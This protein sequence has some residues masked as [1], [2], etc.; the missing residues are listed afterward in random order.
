[1]PKRK[2]TD[3]KGEAIVPSMKPIGGPTGKGKKN[4]PVVPPAATVNAGL[5]QEI[6]LPCTDV[7]L[8]GRARDANAYSSNDAPMSCVWSRTSGPAS[9]TFS[10]PWAEANT[11]TF[12]QAG[13]YV[14]RLTRTDSGA[15]DELTV[16]VKSADSQTAFYVDP[17]YSGGANDGSAAHPW[18]NFSVTAGNAIWTA[19]NAALASNH[20]IVYFSARQAGSDTAETH[21]TEINLWRTDT[22]SHRLTLDGMSKYNAND[23]TPSWQDY[24]GSSRF[25]LDISSGSISIGIQDQ[26]S[27]PMNYTTIRGLEITG[28]NGRATVGGN[29]LVFERNNVHDTTGIGPTVMFHAAV[30]PFTCTQFLGNLERITFRNNTIARGVGEALYIAGTYILESDGGCPSWGNTHSDVLIESN[31]ITDPGYNS[32]GD[33]QGDG[34]DVKA[35]IRNVT[36][37]YNTIANT[38]EGA[39]MITQGA[40]GIVCSGVFTPSVT[41]TNYLIECNRLD[42]CRESITATNQNGLKIRNNILWSNPSVVIGNINVLQKDFSSYVNFDVQVLNNT[43]FGAGILIADANDA[44][45]KN[46]IVSGLNSPNVQFGVYHSISANISSDYNLWTDEA[47]FDGLGLPTEGP[48]SS[49]KPYNATDIFVDTGTG[50]LTLQSGSVAKNTGISLQSEGFAVD[51]AGVDRPQGSEWDRGALELVGG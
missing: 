2:K 5:D 23:A 21:S 40:R 30:Y 7:S 19:I 18:T 45:V 42:K 14:L 31:Q 4:P 17:T 39:R 51:Q 10:A 24:A 8:F 13:T 50:D 48:H 33:D 36:I 32:A 1:M 29:D 22:S 38:D 49:T 9:V 12:T 25:K 27:Y 43:L 15:Y 46:N 41:R 28:T 44:I 26:P 20:V 16:T 34:I 37:R 6:C 3:S 35:G 47:L 11:V